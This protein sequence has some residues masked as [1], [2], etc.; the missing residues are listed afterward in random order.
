MQ[1]TR[2]KGFVV[3]WKSVG[4]EKDVKIDDRRAVCKHKLTTGNRHRWNT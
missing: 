1:I 2:L 4:R 3:E